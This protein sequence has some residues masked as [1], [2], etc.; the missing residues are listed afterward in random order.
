MVPLL[1]ST[2]TTLGKRLSEAVGDVSQPSVIGATVIGAAAGGF[3]GGPLGL[4][5][6]EKRCHESSLSR[7]HR[8]SADP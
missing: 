4:A 7:V 6:G 5:A 8:D 3:V 1:G 2:A